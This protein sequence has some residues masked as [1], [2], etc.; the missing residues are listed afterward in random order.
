MRVTLECVVGSVLELS[1]AALEL[2]DGDEVDRHAGHLPMSGE[3]TLAVRRAASGRGGIRAGAASRTPPTALAHCGSEVQAVLAEF[4]LESP[5]LV[6]FL[7]AKVEATTE[8]TNRDRAAR[9]K[10]LDG[11]D[12]KIESEQLRNAKAAALAEVEAQFGAVA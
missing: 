2:G 8:L 5:A 6:D 4:L 11:E 7:S 12:A 10:K 1:L 9:L 3:W